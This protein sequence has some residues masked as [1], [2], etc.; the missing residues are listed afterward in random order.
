MV[1]VAAAN[2]GQPSVTI[3]QRLPVGLALAL[4][5][6]KAAQLPDSIL[7]HVVGHQH[8][9]TA[10]SMDRYKIAAEDRNE[11]T[12]LFTPPIPRPP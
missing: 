5:A 6:Q 1:W 9:N 3:K 2:P 11:A 4:S 12:A 10:Y 8:L 7:T